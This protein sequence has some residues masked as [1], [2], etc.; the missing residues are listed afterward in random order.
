MA[1]A[2]AAYEEAFTAAG[3]AAA[4]LARVREAVEASSA[5]LD[6]ARFGAAA[7]RRGSTRAR[8]STTSCWKSSGAW[9]MPRRSRLPRARHTRRLR[10]RRAP[11]TR[12]AARSLRSI[13]LRATM[14]SSASSPIAL[15]EAGYVLEDMARETRDYREGVEFDPEGVGAAA[16]A[17]GLAARAAAHVRPAHGGRP[18]RAAAEAATSCRSWTMPPERASARRRLG[19]DRAEAGAR[20]GGCRVGRGARRG[21]AAVRCSRVCA[22]GPSGKWAARARVRPCGRS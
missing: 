19:L 1:V 2:R 10:A 12:W 21:R 15:R 22:D 5:R 18:P 9:S 20:A 3:A 13:R 6:E 17:Y 4:E 7:H 11:S 14:R 16:G 8:A